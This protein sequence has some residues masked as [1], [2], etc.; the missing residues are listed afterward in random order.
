MTNPS[1]ISAGLAN[2]FSKKDV[3]E[4]IQMI[5]SKVSEIVRP[6]ANVYFETLVEHKYTSSFAK[7]MEASILKSLP[8]AFRSLGSPYKTVLFKALDNVTKLGDSVLEFINKTLPDAVHKEALTYQSAS[9]IRIVELMDFFTT[10]TVR[11]L[12][13]MTAAET[14]IQAFGKA[15]SAPYTKAEMNYLTVNINA[16]LQTLEFLNDNFS[17]IT[18]TLL[19]IPNILIV[20]TD[21]A[22]VS[23]IHGKKADPLNLGFIPGISWIFHSIGIRFVDWEIDRYECAKKERRIVELRLEA[24]RQKA[25]TGESNARLESTIENYERELTLLRAKIAHMEDK[26]K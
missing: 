25:T 24:L 15:D 8:P 9:V 2:S 19:N 4:K 26:M 11:L 22:Q 5:T 12:V 17:D 16:Y 20:D 10:Y 1:L 6:T 3:R 7:S 23:V 18:K 14:N 13:A 21:P